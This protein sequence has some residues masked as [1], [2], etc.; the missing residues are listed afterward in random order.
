MRRVVL[1]YV[2]A[3]LLKVWLKRRQLDS[4]ASA[5]GM[6]W[7][8]ILVEV[9]EENLT[10]HRYVTGKERKYFNCLSR[11]LWIL[12]DTKIKLNRK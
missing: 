1:F 7:Y 12:F 9:S 4:L 3:D 2:F 11:S 10:S 8:V 6:L 5:F